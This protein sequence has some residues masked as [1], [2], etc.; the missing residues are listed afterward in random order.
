MGDA[1]KERNCGGRGRRGRAGG[2]QPGTVEKGRTREEFDKTGLR[3]KRSAPVGGV[4]ERG[5][6][7]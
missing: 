3:L 7:E 1:D 2:T 4:G 6:G 5:E